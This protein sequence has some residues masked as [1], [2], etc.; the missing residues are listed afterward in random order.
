M[1]PYDEFVQERPDVTRGEYESY[2]AYLHGNKSPIKGTLD[3]INGPEVNFL[4]KSMPVATAVLPAVAGILGARYGARKAAKRLAN[5]S[6]GNLLDQRHDS[7]QTYRKEGGDG[8][9]EARSSDYGTARATPSAEELAARKE[10]VDSAYREYNR[11]NDLVENETL[12]QVLL[13]GGG[14]LTAAALV[15]STLEQVRRA[16]KGKAPEEPDPLTATQPSL[17]VA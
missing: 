13:Y 16:L 1:L 5:D 14:S 7:Y 15:G 17:P 6:S 9:G 4:G 2:K 11:V 10:L 3:G 12:K 8:A